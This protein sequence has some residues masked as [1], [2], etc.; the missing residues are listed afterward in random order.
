MHELFEKKHTVPKCTLCPSGE[1][2]LLNM[3]IPQVI[4]YCLVHCLF[5]STQVYD[6]ARAEDGAK[7]ADINTIFE[8]LRKDHLIPDARDKWKEAWIRF[9]KTYPEHAVPAIFPQIGVKNARRRTWSDLIAERTDAD[10]IFNDE[11]HI[12]A[13]NITCIY[14]FWTFN[15]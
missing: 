3:G 5:P 11:V 7:F 2:T 15:L 4:D 8:G 9:V 12:L 14:I 13:A 10:N 1:F 6:H